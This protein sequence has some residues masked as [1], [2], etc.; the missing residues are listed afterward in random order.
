MVKFDKTIDGSMA[1]VCRVIYSVDQRLRPTRPDMLFAKTPKAKR[2]VRNGPEAYARV[3]QLLEKCGTPA[4]MALT[5]DI[6]GICQPMFWEPLGIDCCIE[7]DGKVTFTEKD[8]GGLLPRYLGAVE[9]AKAAREV[10]LN[11]I[12][13]ARQ[14]IEEA[15]RTFEKV[16]LKNAGQAVLYHLSMPV[17]WYADLNYTQLQPDVWQRAPYPPHNRYIPKDDVSVYESSLTHNQFVTPK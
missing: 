9:D 4:T 17:L 1:A 14:E 15:Y 13:I 7:D 3:M 16:A 12:K 11:K 5:D 8:P 10:E 2:Y 6:R